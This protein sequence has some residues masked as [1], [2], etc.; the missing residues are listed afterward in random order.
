MVVFCL[1]I[2][3]TVVTQGGVS[4]IFAQGVD[5]YNQVKKTMRTVLHHRRVFSTRCGF[6]FLLPTVRC[7]EVQFYRCHLGHGFSR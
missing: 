1:A 6:F 5:K 4:A 3:S 7:G 2:L